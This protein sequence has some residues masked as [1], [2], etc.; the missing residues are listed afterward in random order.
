MTGCRI[1]INEH[2]LYAQMR[3]SGLSYADI[4]RQMKVPYHRVWHAVNSAPV[5]RKLKT[6]VIVKPR[7]RVQA[8]SRKC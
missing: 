8:I 2:R 4:A 1:S 5:I 6:T 7:V 3:K